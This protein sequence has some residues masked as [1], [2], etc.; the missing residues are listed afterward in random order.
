MVTERRKLFSADSIEE[1]KD[2]VLNRQDSVFIPIGAAITGAYSEN[3][4]W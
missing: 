4:N 3:A 1:I 2:L